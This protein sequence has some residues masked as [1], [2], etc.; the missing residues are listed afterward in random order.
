MKHFLIILFSIFELSLYAGSD[1]DNYRKYISCFDREYNLYYSSIDD[2][3]NYKDT[4]GKSKDAFSTI[5]IGIYDINKDT[6]RLLF[7]KTNRS[8]WI[9][10]FYFEQLY[11]STK[12]MIRFNDFTDD[13]YVSGNIENNFFINKRDVAKS[14]I[15]VTYSAKSEKYSLWFSD[16]FGNNLRQIIDFNDKTDYHI[17]VYNQCIRL[18]SKEN[19]EIKIKDIKY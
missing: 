14:L 12:R 3:I 16:K 7:D 1:G 19:S 5:N 9:V 6:F 11:D 2:N 4:K 13:S 15:I 8:I 17:D 18:I 10:D